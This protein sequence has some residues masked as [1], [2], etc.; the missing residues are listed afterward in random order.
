MKRVP[1]LFATGRAALQLFP[2]SVEEMI[3]RFLFP[4]AN[5]RC[6]VPVFSDSTRVP[7]PKDVEF[8]GSLQPVYW[9]QLVELRSGIAGANVL[10]PSVDCRICMKVGVT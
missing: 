1:F 6:S 8:A 9:L 2:T 7:P 4:G 5:T 3:E 10:P